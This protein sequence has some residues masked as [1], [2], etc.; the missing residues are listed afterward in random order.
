MLKATL[1]NPVKLKPNLTLTLTLT[2]NTHTGY[3]VV[4]VFPVSNPVTGLLSQQIDLTLT[5]TPI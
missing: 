3:I 5:L 4:R 2:A 1:M